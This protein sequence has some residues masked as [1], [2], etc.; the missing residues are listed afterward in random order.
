MVSLLVVLKAA[1]LQQEALALLGLVLGGRLL[2][3]KTD[4]VVEDLIDIDLQLGRSLNEEAVV[5]ASS[6]LLTLLSSNDT[7]IIQ[8]AL[9]AHKDHGDIIGILHA[10]DLLAHVGKIVESTKS[11]DGIHKNEALAVLHVKI[12]H[13]GELLST[14]SIEDLQHALLA[15]DIHLLPIRILDCGIVLL[16]EDTLNELDSKCRLAHT[17]RTKHDNFVLLKRHC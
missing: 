9:V 17:T 16:D 13:G 11:D 1:R 5:E 6:H 7:G 3:N 10:E 2:I 12:T 14:G 4:E 15:V 8:I